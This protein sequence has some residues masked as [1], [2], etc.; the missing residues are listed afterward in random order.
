MKQTPGWEN[1]SGMY[2]WTEIAAKIAKEESA[3]ENNEFEHPEDTETT[4]AIWTSCNILR[5]NFD[6]MLW[7]IK[8]YAERN[9]LFHNSINDLA[10]KGK[11]AE[12]AKMINDDIRDLPSVM[13]FD[14][15]A[16]EEMLLATLTELRDYWFD[17]DWTGDPEDKLQPETWVPRPAFLDEV[18]AAKNP[19]KAKIVREQ[20][21]ENVSR[22]IS[23]RIRKLEEH[24]VKQLKT[25]PTQANFRRRG[26]Q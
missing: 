22:G 5:L 17:T 11:H 10:G 15:R 7:A 13:P 26:P 6:R 1:L 4:R 8:A 12:L 18:K 23:K 21:S 20:H 19:E 14:M 16:D 24:L 2:K 25:K 9:Q 3:W